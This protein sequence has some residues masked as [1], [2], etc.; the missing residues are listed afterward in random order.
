MP[1]VQV[2][3]FKYG[4][5]RRRKR[6]VGIPGSLWTLKNAHISRGGDIERMKKWVVYA[7]LPAGTFGLTTYYGQLITFGSADLA[8]SMP[9]TVQYQRLPAPTGTTGLTMT[10]VLDTEIFGDNLYVISRWSDGSIRHYY[11]GVYLTDWDAVSA[12]TVKPAHVVYE[13]GVIASDSPDVQVLMSSGTVLRL[14]ANVP[15]VAFTVA[16]SGAGAT[17]TTPQANVAPV[18]EV[19]AQAQI[20]VIGGPSGVVA[21]AIPYVTSLIIEGH[22]MIQEAIPWTGSTVAMANALVVAINTYGGVPGVRATQT[23]ST[24]NVIGVEGKGATLNGHA[25][26][27]AFDAG[28]NLTKTNFAGG[29]TEVVAVAQVSEVN[30]PGAMTGTTQLTVT[31]NGVVYVIL[32]SAASMGNQAMAYK[33]RM[34]CTAGTLLRYSGLNNP[35]AWVAGGS[36]VPG[37]IDMPTEGEGAERLIAMARYDQSMAVFGGS[38]IR[39]WNL[40]VDPA[41]N[42]QTQS[43]NN[44]GAAAQ[45][46]V[47]QY[48]DMDVFYLDIP[49]IRSLKAR[50][51]VTTAAVNDIG[52]GID[53][54]LQDYQRTIPRSQL[55]RAV[56]V[57]EPLDGRYILAIGP[58]MLVLSAFVNSKISAWSYYEPGFICTAFARLRQRLYARDATNVYV[59]GGV[60]GTTYP[61]EDETEVVVETP[62]ISANDPGTFKL[63]KAFSAVCTNE[64]TVDILLDPNDETKTIPVGQVVGTTFVE[65]F[66]PVEGAGNLFAVRMTTKRGGEASFSSFAVDFDK[67]K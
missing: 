34:W 12:A 55:L 41:K 7:A 54:W 43:L 48:G 50:N 61:A 38:Q 10:G 20:N 58:R 60:G 46:A 2:T 33:Q 26:T 30:Y 52:T 11:N 36:G 49:G 1:Q 67:A 32:A 24:V 56:G 44:T 35:A 31:I 29:V 53:P 51:A 45:Q 65:G 22:E 37:Y 6:S 4:K 57:I 42:T 19:S 64:W 21:T 59:Y 66:T 15:G 40:D 5:D 18:A 63:L 8:G 16:A 9:S 27:L 17:I 39:L 62:F 13:L 3:D 25:M 14:T 28:L 23:G 47:V